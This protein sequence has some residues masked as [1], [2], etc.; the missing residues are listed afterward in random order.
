MVSSEPADFRHSKD[1]YD[2]AH[3]G[4]FPGGQLGQVPPWHLDDA[5]PRIKELAAL[6]ALRG[7]IA[8]IGCGLGSNIIYLGRHD[9]SVTGLDSSPA[10]IRQAV[11]RA[12]DAGVDVTF[13]VADATEL[14][15]Y[16][17]V[18][19]TIL[20]TGLLHCLDAAARREYAE[21]VYRAARP[22]ARWFISCFSTRTV[23]GVPSDLGMSEW[24]IRELLAAAGWMIDYFG[25]GAYE[26]EF[27]TYAPIAM[28]AGMAEDTKFPEHVRKLRTI[29]PLIPS[30]EPVYVP[31]WV[32]YARRP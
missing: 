18:F 23:N 21:A 31:A 1:F 29:L 24:E 20:E 16:D 12:D 8:D 5:Q 2:G 26:F 10:A 28:W 11:Q 7:D 9:Y 15:G 19:D 13:A 27:D 17:G 3:G 32:I 25:S 4:T 30:G 22:D 6:G 14:A